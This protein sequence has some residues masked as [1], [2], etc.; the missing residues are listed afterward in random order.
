MLTCTRTE[1]PAH[2]A[3]LVDCLWELRGEWRSGN[4]YLLPSVCVDI[5]IRMEGTI[6]VFR[7]GGWQRIPDRVTIGS[8]DRVITL[9]QPGRLWVIGI[10]LTPGCASVLGR[11]ASE[12]RNQ[13]LPLSDLAPDLDGSIEGF[14]LGLRARR[15]KVAD[16]FRI[17]EGRSQA[18]ADGAIFHAACHLARGAYVH[19][20]ARSLHVSRRHLYRRFL[21][22]VG[23]TPSAFR[24]LA[25]FSLVS[26]MAASAH[27]PRWSDLAVSAGYFDQAHLARDFQMFAGGPP[28]SIFSAAWYANFLAPSQ[29]SHPYKTW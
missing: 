1:V 4:D 26:R 21:N 15:A 7:D 6:E 17:L 13:I 8:Q 27:R 20:V 19:G 23:W 16:L 22:E 12:L 11:K 10:Q 28:T 5:A 29:M 25:R 14:S 24:R 2:L 9:R 3:D 18:R